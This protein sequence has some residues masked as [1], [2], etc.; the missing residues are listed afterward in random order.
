MLVSDPLSDISPFEAEDLKLFETLANHTA[1]ALE[2]GR[3]EQSLEQLGRLKE[4]LHHQ[5]SHDPLTGLANR[6]LFTQVVASRLESRDPGGL[7]PVVL[8][9]DLDDFK[10]VNDSLGHA[11]GRCAA[12]RRRRSA[13]FGD[14]RQATWRR[15]SAATSSRCSCSTRPT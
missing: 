7:V 9:V 2:N 12:G 11:A 6:S 13:P 3:L 4:E 8:F 5:A 15:D 14:A 10:L 1:I